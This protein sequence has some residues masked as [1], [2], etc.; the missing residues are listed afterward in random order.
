MSVDGVRPSESW[1]VSSN[2]ECKEVWG[3]L[4]DTSMCSVAIGEHFHR[5]PPPH[6]PCWCSACREQGG[7]PATIRIWIQVGQYLNKLYLL[8]STFRDSETLEASARASRFAKYFQPLNDLFAEQNKLIELQRSSFQTDRSG[9]RPPV[10][11]TSG[12]GHLGQGGSEALYYSD[13]LPG[14]PQQPRAPGAVEA[15][16]SLYHLTSVSLPTYVARFRF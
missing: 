15:S 11:L 5:P 9:G 8:I 16:P 7:C 4:I 14:Q 2:L 12:S 1:K 6:T 13:T 3:P 10:F